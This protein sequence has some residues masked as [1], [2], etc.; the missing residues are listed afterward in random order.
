VHLPSRSLTATEAVRAFG[1]AS[2]RGANDPRCAHGPERLR[3]AGLVS[4]PDIADLDLRWGAVLHAHSDAAR[5]TVETVADVCRRLACCVRDTVAAGARFTVLGG[6]H[7]CALGTWSGAREALADRGPIG[8]VWMDAHMDA[9]TP[10]TSPS[11]NLHGMPLACL[12]GRGDLCLTSLAARGPVLTPEH[13]CLIGVRSYEY[14]EAELLERLGVRVFFM[15]EVRWR[16]LDVIVPEALR[17]VCRG[18]AG[19]GVSLDLDALDP[20]DAPGVSLPVADGLRAAETLDALRSLGAQ[21]DL[22]GIEIAEFNPYR[23]SDGVTARLIAQLLHA[24]LSPG[25][26]DESRH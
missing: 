23:D 5:S 7:T 19:F 9:H 24:C 21:A 8:L 12:L 20:L 22:L 13:V 17:I 18:T 4:A 16:G 11:G 26:H 10:Q 14:D 25:D 3:A 2:G 6:D 1:F 15:D